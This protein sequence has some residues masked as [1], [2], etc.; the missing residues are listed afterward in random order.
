MRSPPLRERQL[1][2][3][4]FG[5]LLGNVRWLR[6]SYQHGAGSVLLSRLGGETASGATLGAAGSAASASYEADATRRRQQLGV[7]RSAWG[8]KIRL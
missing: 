4:G 3:T 6:G 7:Q 5:D 2:H 8:A 1:F